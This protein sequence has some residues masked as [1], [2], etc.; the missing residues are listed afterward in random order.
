MLKENRLIEKRVGRRR[1]RRRL[2]C[3][4]KDVKT[5]EHERPLMQMCVMVLMEEGV[6]FVY[7]LCCHCH[8]VMWLCLGMMLWQLLTFL[9]SLW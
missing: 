1:R 4:D 6:V 9:V 2:I 8:V 7:A 5:N 3:V